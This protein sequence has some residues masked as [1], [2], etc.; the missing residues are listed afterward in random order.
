MERAEPQEEVPKDLL[1]KILR[2]AS[3]ESD[4][5][6]AVEMARVPISMQEVDPKKI[7]SISLARLDISSY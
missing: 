4:Q 6:S 2:I 5:N 7:N 3:I 1:T